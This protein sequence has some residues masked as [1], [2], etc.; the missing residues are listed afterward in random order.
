MYPA[1]MIEEA[2]FLKKK[3]SEKSQKIAKYLLTFKK[4]VGMSV[5]KFR[6]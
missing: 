1:T 6:K 4:S 3:Y 5:K 2:F